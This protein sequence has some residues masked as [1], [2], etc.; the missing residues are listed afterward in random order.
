[1]NRFRILPG[2]TAVAV[3]CTIIFILTQVCGMANQ[4]EAVILCGAYYKPFILC[5]EYWRLLSAGFVH[6]GILHL[7]VNMMSLF[8]LGSFMEQKLGTFKYMTVL[9][10]SVAGGSLFTFCM[11]GNTVSGG[12]S[13]GLY[14]LLAGFS[15]IIFS[16]DLAKVPAV[17][18]AL[19]R[20]Y[21]ICIL[22]NFMPSIA[23]SAHIGG[24][25][26]GLF[27]TGILSEDV[28]KKISIVH[29]R[30]A[31]VLMLAVLCFFSWQR[32]NLPAG[33]YYLMSDYNI[34]KKESEIGMK[35]YAKNMAVRLDRLYDMEG[36]LEWLIGKED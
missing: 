12:L 33:Q 13:G 16:M 27:L 20:T 18:S 8:N 29:L 19:I 26:T 23:V 11:D 22:I 36:T 2:T 35:N 34:L 24:Y 7:A 28:R 30:T 15:L 31:A 14:G 9:L 17:R 6:I 25:V 4:A 21:L 32:R 1:M 5:G 3:I 10:C